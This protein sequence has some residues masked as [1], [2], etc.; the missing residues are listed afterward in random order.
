MEWFDVVGTIGVALI[1][2]AYAGTQTRRM[3]PEGLQYSIL[4]LVGAIL[5]TVSLNYAFNM[6]S[7]IIEIFW[8]IFS[9]WGI[10]RWLQNRK[11]RKGDVAEK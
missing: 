4:N 10:W 7:F 9:L 1:V 8:I 2:Y 11:R 6:A 5:I 3:N